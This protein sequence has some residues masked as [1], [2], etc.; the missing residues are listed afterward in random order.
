M[1][2]KRTREV[3]AEEAADAR[4]WDGAA[5]RPRANADVACPR[6]LL[7]NSQRARGGKALWVDCD[8][9]HDDAFALYLAAWGAVDGAGGKKKTV[10]EDDPTP[11]VLAGVSTV[12]GNQTIEK[13]TANARRVL[14]WIDWGGARDRYGSA[15]WECHR[16]MTEHCRVY[17][18]AGQPLLREARICEEI[19]GESGMD[20]VDGTSA[21]PEPE[22][23]EKRYVK[24]GDEPAAVAM[25]EAVKKAG[26]DLIIVATGPLTNVALMISMYRTELNALTK[27]PTIFFMGGA[28]G[29]GNTGA[30]AEFNV[31]CDPE[32]AHVVLESGLPLYMIPLEVTHTALATP[33]VIATLREKALLHPA[34]EEHAKRIEALLTFFAQTY[35]RVF[36]FDHPPLHDPCAV[37]AAIEFAHASSDHHDPNDFHPSFE[38]TL[39][40]VDVERASALTYGQTVVDRWR[41]SGRPVN[42]RLARKMNV[43]A[44]W[45]ALARAIELH[46]A[47]ASSHRDATPA[48]TTVGRPPPS[49]RP[50]PTD[51]VRVHDDPTHDTTHTT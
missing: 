13:T 14:D 50:R 43:R 22:A 26:G 35:A 39:E 34:G 9:G 2:R 47:L 51:R 11:L 10:T 1:P 30:R 33:E 44:F 18:G 31:Q 8:P 4:H 5:R 41:T 20:A 12:A 29:E 17:E 45:N 15:E 27:R 40:R 38:Y 36:R 6:C 42:V 46:A 24:V 23:R 25:F 32:A 37:W 28:V 49:D 21:L 48:E 16:F 3:E 7:R 19:H